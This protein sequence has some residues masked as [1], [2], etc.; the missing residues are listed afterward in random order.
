MKLGRIKPPPFLVAD[1]PQATRAQILAMGVTEIPT[2]DPN[3]IMVKSDITHEIARWSRCGR[4]D[5][6]VEE[7]YGSQPENEE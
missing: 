1:K 4:S 2:G 6:F 7:E 5:Y 3:L